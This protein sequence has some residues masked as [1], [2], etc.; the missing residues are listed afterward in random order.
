MKTKLILIVTALL[1]SFSSVANAQTLGAAELSAYVIGLINGEV[2]RTGTQQLNGT[3]TVGVD[4]TGHDVKLFGATSGAYLLWDESADAL[5]LTGTVIGLDMQ[6]AYTNAAID[7][8]DVVL[9]HSGSSGPVLIRAGTYGS[10]VTS[11]DPHQSGM[12]R[13]YSR[14]SALTE[15]GTGFYDRGIFVSMKTTG[16]KGQMAISGLVEVEATVSGNGPLNVK[17]SEFVVSLLETGSKLGT[18]AGSEVHGMY[19]GWFKIHA[20]DGATTHT[21]SKKAPIWLDNSIN[22]INAMAGEEYSIYAT[23]GNTVDAFVGF[24][25]GTGA[26]WTNLFYFDETAYDED[27]ICS[28][29]AKSEVNSDKSIMISLNGTTY[30][31]PIFVVGN[32]E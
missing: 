11:S 27:P 17:A 7:L 32:M 25:T 16:A 3:L 14:N 15:D 31:I 30:Y 10:P 23:S 8:T 29:G 20:K 1:L 13:L 21:N 19:A 12:I 28:V 18:S 2:T 24:Q 5:L 6:G 26:G 9:N 22:G 4:D